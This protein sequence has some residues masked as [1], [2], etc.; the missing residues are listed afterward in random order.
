MGRVVSRGQPLSS[1]VLHNRGKGLATRDYGEGAL[2]NIL[3]MF[4]V[5]MT[6]TES[7]VLVIVLLNWKL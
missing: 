4:I 1:G 5:V 2:H 7:M 6:S 3:N